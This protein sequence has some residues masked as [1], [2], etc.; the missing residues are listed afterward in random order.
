MKFRCEGCDANCILEISSS[1]PEDIRY[2]VIDG[3][4]ERWKK[5]S[6]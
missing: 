4:E 5:E 2:C 6:S 3:N 1:R